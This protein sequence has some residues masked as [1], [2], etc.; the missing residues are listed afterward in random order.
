MSASAWKIVP[1]AERA[2]RVANA[3][4]RVGLAD[5]AAAWPRELSGGQAQRVAI[6]RAFGAATN[7][8]LLLDEPFSALDAFTRAT[9]QDQLLDLLGRRQTDTAARHP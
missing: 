8:W 6:A 3:L 7:R 4:K 1:K 5:K 2:Q 9:L